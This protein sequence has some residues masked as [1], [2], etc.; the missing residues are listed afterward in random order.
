MIFRADSMAWREI[1]LCRSSVV[2][3]LRVAVSNVILVPI[4]YVC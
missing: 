3:E 1:V 2:Q 4:M